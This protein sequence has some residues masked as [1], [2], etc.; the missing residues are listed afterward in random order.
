[1]NDDHYI[2]PIRFLDMTYPQVMCILTRGK[3]AEEKGDVAVRAKRV[4][5]D[6]KAGRYKTG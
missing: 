5:A 6:F 1:L 2:D 4:L 3:A